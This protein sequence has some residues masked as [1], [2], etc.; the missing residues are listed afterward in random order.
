MILLIAN[1]T[2]EVFL[3]VARGE[4]P[5]GRKSHLSSSF[6]GLNEKQAE[7]IEDDERSS[8]SRMNLEKEGLFFR[9]LGALFKKRAANF[10]RDKKAWVC[11]TIIP[12]VFVLIGFVVYIVASKKRSL[13]PLTL[14]LE[15]YNI[16]VQQ[17]PI[18]PIPFNSPNQPFTCEPAECMY[19]GI[20]NAGSGSSGIVQSFSTGE[21]YAYCGALGSPNFDSFVNESVPF[22][23]F[24]CSIS[25]S[26][27]IM[28]EID[29][30]HGGQSVSTETSNISS[31]SDS[32]SS[33][34]A[35]RSLANSCDLVIRKLVKKVKQYI[36][37]ISVRSYLVQP[38]I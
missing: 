37:I 24:D 10:K 3:L 20:R 26:S 6:F 38:R 14:S 2:D 21:V 18:N 7:M 23:E 28:A 17:E 4:K 31:V 33:F 27:S 25:D 5:E 36:R 22:V 15:D 9:H 16:D 29:N 19:R 13:A 30:F 35:L 8:K 1:F 34:I 12:S 32:M 11:T